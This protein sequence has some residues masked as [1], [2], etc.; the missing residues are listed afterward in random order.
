MLIKGGKDGKIIEAGTCGRKRN[1]QTSFAPV[2]NEDHMPP[3]E[4]PQP[5]ESQIALLH[6][7]I[8]GGA[9]FTGK[10]KEFQ[11][12]DKIKPVLLALQKA[13][14]V[15]KGLTGIPAGPVE[16]ADDKIIEELKDNHVVVLPVAQNSNYLMVNFV[17]DSVIN[18]EDLKLLTS[19]KK[20]LIWLKLGFTNLGDEQ[21]S[22]IAK[23]TN[24]TQLSVEHTSIT[25]KGVESLKHLEN[26]EYL[27]LVG[28]QVTKEGIL[29]LK[30][31]KKLH[32]LYLFQTRVDKTDWAALQK[33]FPKTQIDSGGYSVQSLPT[34][35]MEVKEVRREQ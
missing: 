11:Q 32:S 27:N 17:T 30:G 10:V 9:N 6:W 14:E 24:I 29:E 33:A 19:L 8:D 15:K 22:S 12:P 34:D 21:I 20:Q 13:P 2:D 3:K 4:K 26:L 35:T 28:T 16:K 25:D 18:E 7:W 23:L 1:D 31:L 5:T